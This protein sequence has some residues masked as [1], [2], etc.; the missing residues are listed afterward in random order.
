MPKN[1]PGSESSENLTLEIT[2]PLIYSSPEDSL[3]VEQMSVECYLF[4]FL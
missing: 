2:N 4:S 1:L 3:F